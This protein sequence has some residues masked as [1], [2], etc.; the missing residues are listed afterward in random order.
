MYL[1]Y[2]LLSA[3]LFFVSSLQLDIQQSLGRYPTIARLAL[4]FEAH[5][6]RRARPVV[7]RSS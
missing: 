7:V 1:F 4:E 3:V 5:A 2:Q 6:F